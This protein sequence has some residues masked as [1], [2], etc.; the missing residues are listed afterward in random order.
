MSADYFAN[1]RKVYDKYAQV[2]E[3]QRDIDYA[4]EF[5]MIE[6]REEASKQLDL[7]TNKIINSK[8]SDSKGKQRGQPEQTEQTAQ[9]ESGMLATKRK[10]QRGKGH[11]NKSRKI[12][13]KAQTAEQKRYYQLLNILSGSIHAGNTSKLAKQ[14]LDNQIKRGLSNGWLTKQQ[15]SHI[16][17]NT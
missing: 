2:R 13:S 15:A 11:P 9:S 7:L 17:K 5:D 4:R 3:T 16:K 8:Q 6:E 10:Q 1:K 12:N 14:Q